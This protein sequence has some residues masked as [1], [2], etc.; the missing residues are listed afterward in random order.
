MI[1]I[2]KK[3][4]PELKP[5]K[6]QLIIILLLGLLS[7]GL[8]AMVP[9]LTGRLFAAWDN[10]DKKVAYAIPPIVA[11]IWIFSS[12]A[13]YFHMYTM[14]YMA[15]R[16]SLSQRGRLM[17]KY[18][19]LNISFF[20]NFESGSGGLISRMLNDLAIILNG[21]H[22]VADM[23]RAP[24]MAVAMLGYLLYLDW[25]LTLFII[26]A[27]PIVVTVM[28]K[29]AVSLRKHS[30][31]SQ[32]AMEEITR[33]LK[34][35]LDGT[36]VIQSFLLEEEIRKKFK[37]QADHFLQSRV[38]II[39]R[40]EMA[41]PIAESLTWVFVSLLLLYI[42]FRVFDSQMSTANVM[43]F[44]IA[45]GM[46][47]D[48]TRKL[49]DGYIKIQQAGVGLDRFNT[50]MQTESLLKTPT[51]TVQFPLNWSVIEFKN[52]S[53]AYKN[54]LVLKNIN[55]VIKRNEK[56]ALVGSSGSGKS[57]M[58]NLLQRFF[59]PTSGQVLID[60]ISI[61]QFALNDLRKN[62]ALVTQDVFLFND[63]IQKNIQM[64]NLAASVEKIHTAAQMANA[65]GFIKQTPDGYNTNVGDF[66]GRMSGGEKQR[67]SIARAI[68]KDAPILVLDEATS[69]LDSESEQE[70]QKGL[71]RLLE[72]RT[73]FVIAHRLSTIASA[74]RILVMKKGEI[75]EEGTHNQLV[76]KRG[77]YYKFSQ[78]Q[79][80]D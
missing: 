61:D 55:V 31:R 43:S 28:R 66:G 2:W 21:I 17:D 11:V 78:M 80:L 36:K 18:L 74:S 44:L 45:M 57:T 52:V 60:G 30:H 9:E 33:T 39:S 65:E 7:E 46:L 75:V 69:A 23:V 34:E 25:T 35:S 38:K 24:F 15:D 19:S 13:H 54:E 73:A 41:G 10:H 53:F 5:F 27:L 47:Q 42:G 50:M 72:G 79:N 37:K 68:L 8:K 63:S 76:E 4:W 16:V 62:I 49:Q 14:K 40:E 59:D 32:E 26:V 22:K 1:A 12:I 56:I 77:E 58:V 48:A 29:I 51:Q 6:K 71:Q 20:Q 64:G 70:V 67:I 3:L